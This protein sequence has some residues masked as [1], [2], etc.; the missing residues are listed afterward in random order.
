MSK[1]QAVLTWQGDLRFNATGTTGR[2]TAIDGDQGIAPNPMELA[3]IAL[4]GCSAMDIIAILQKKRQDVTGFEVRLDGTRADEHPRV[5][6]EVAMVYVVRGR[7]VDE[8]AVV[9][10]IELSETKYCSVMAMLRAS[11]AI[12]TR[13]EIVEE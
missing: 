8:A 5:Y 4:G 3:L 6:T 7:A 10:A 1:E 11:V 2:Q 13:Y 12:T 9:R